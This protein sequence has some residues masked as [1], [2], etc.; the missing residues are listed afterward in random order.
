[1]QGIRADVKLASNPE[2]SYNKY[3]LPTFI[4]LSECNFFSLAY[5]VVDECVLAN[6][7]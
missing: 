5:T 3:C 7:A 6:A 4:S 2:L 1:V